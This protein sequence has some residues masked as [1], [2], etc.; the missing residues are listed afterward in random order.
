MGGIGKTELATQY[1]LKHKDLKTYPGGICWLNARE[2]NIGSQIISFTKIN[3]DKNPP[4][5]LEKLEEKV[6]WCWKNW[7]G[8]KTLIIID[9]VKEYKNIKPYIP[10]NESKFKILI[11]TRN[12]NL[13]GSFQTLD[14]KV[15]DEKSALELLASFIDESRTQ[16]ELE[17]AKDL[18]AKLGFLPLG[19]ELVG[20]YLQSKPDLSLTKIQER[21]DSKSLK[22]RSLQNI[23]NEMTAQRGVEAAFELSWE[24]L[25]I[26]EQKLACLISL[27]ALASIPWSLVEKCLPEE[28]KEN[29][30]DSRDKLLSLS[31][32]QRKEKDIYQLHKLIQEFLRDKQRKLANTEE[33][34]QNLCITITE[35]I[36]EIPQITT[37]K[38]INYFTSLIPHITEIVTLYQNWLSNEDLIWPFIGLSKFYENQGAY[39]QALPW[40]ENCLLATKERLGEEHPDVAASLNNLAELY[41]DQGRYEEA[42]PLH[43]EALK[44][45]KKTLGEKNLNIAA[46]LNNLA[47]LYH[48]QRRYEEAETLFLEALKI[49]KKLIGEEN[50]NVAASLNNLAGLY[51]D[52]ERYEEAELLYLEALEI[53]KKLIGEEHPN[54]ATNLDNLAL[55]YDKQK[56]Y[57]EAEL[58]HLKALEINKKILGK[59]H[60]NVAAS[61]NNLAGLYHNQGKY[62]EAEPL[63]IEALK[64]H[65]KLLGEENPK[66][67]TSLNNLA[68][69]YHDQGKY[70]EAEPLF[71]EALEMKKKLL[72]EENPNTALNLWYLGSL[73]RQQ[74]KY[75][76]AKPLYQK[77]LEILKK[78][79]GETHPDTIN[80]QKQYKELIDSQNLKNH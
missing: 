61:L 48:D 42:E 71:L 54:I 76:E 8:E 50:L 24:E 57:K 77:A 69:L 7:Q 37:L 13:G 25:N 78:T 72:G 17:E 22:H 21:L 2:Q 15:L 65:K 53:T 18:C 32:L 56:R 30:E 36:K 45:S 68:G 6:A 79:I 16:K 23:S 74:K 46:S 28:N 55:L 1:S 29:L 12:K 26:A 20:R 70:K 27:F 14:L 11:T 5:Y 44:I 75:S 67:A 47:E 64:I 49:T 63:Y 39:K 33:Q 9:D 58:L 10:P 38:S 80:C 4:E 59:E 43:L 41:H 66:I 52:Q 19:L 40:R 31:L 51:D 34:K 62:K 73:Y 35:I 3:L 60:L